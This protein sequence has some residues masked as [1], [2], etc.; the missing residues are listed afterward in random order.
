[1]PGAGQVG[2]EEA[3]IGHSGLKE[4]ETAKNKEIKMWEPRRGLLKTE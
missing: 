4:P 1:M 2:S 3:D